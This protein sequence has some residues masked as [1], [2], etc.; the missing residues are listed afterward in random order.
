MGNFRS[1]RGG[2]FGGR[3]RDSRGGGRGFGGGGFGGNRGGYGGGRDRDSRRGEMHDVI[4]SK[5]GKDCQVPFKPTTSK[6]V[7][8]NDCFKKEGDSSAFRGGSSAGSSDQF[9]QI[10]AKLDKIIKILSELEIDVDEDLELGDDEDIDEDEDLDDEEG[11]DDEEDEED[12]EDESSIDSNKVK[13]FK[14]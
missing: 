9:N 13:K 4:C 14:N 3:G 1:D 11:N 5:C 2:G 12:S 8:C 10:N 6:P 7:Y